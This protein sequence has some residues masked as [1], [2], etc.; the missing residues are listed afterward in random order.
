MAQLKLGNYYSYEELCDILGERPYNNRAYKAEQ[1]KRWRERYDITSKTQKGYKIIGARSMIQIEADKFY[2]SKRYEIQNCMLAV[3]V[4]SLQK[5]CI[6]QRDNGADYAEKIFDISMAMTLFKF[7]GNGYFR[8]CELKD[9]YPFLYG[10][11]KFQLKQYA[12]KCLRNSL[13]LLKN[14]GYLDYEYT[15]HVYDVENKCWRKATEHEIGEIQ[16]ATSE[17]LRQYGLFKI[18]DLAYVDRDTNIMVWDDITCELIKRINC[19]KYRPVFYVW[20]DKKNMSEA[21]WRLFGQAKLRKMNSYL[22]SLYCKNRDYLPNHI[23]D[24]IQKFKLSLDKLFDQ[25]IEGIDENIPGML[26]RFPKTERDNFF[27]FDKVSSDIFADRIDWR[28]KTV[29]KYYDICDNAYIKEL[30]DI[31]REVCE[32]INDQFFS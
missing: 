19:S 25:V 27:M 30:I 20:M 3:I 4:D 18:S 9:K 15:K 23:E 24:E 2:E 14:R 17:I 12:S 29:Q 26:S 5:C 11:C 6:V 22:N 10:K 13:S 21:K 1:F 28:D 32:E 8:D 7:S 31:Y 16:V